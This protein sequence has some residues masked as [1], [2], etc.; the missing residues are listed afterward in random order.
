MNFEIIIMHCY[1]T[2]NLNKKKESFHF[3]CFLITHSLLNPVEINFQDSILDSPSNRV[4]WENYRAKRYREKKSHRNLQLKVIY[5]LQMKLNASFELV[6]K[7]IWENF[8]ACHRRWSSSSWHSSKNL[9]AWHYQHKFQTESCGR[10]KLS[11]L[12]HNYDFV[13]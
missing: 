13:N 8:N 5:A 9:S 10:W 7:R 3:I 4:W 6:I 11:F 12:L 2:Y 1:E